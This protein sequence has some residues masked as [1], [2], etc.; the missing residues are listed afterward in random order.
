MATVQQVKQD[1]RTLVDAMV[2]RGRMLGGLRLREV[3]LVL[4]TRHAIDSRVASDDD[5]VAMARRL[6][7]AVRGNR[8]RRLAGLRAVEVAAIEQLE[9][10]LQQYH[11]QEDN[12]GT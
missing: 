3:E 8:G 1:A 7:R 5:A 6:V 4:W 2:A 9:K 10:T 11:N 12:D